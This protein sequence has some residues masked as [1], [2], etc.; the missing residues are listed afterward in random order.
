MADLRYFEVGEM[1]YAA[2]DDAGAAALWEE[3]TGEPAPEVR[4]VAGDAELG[5]VS[6]RR[7][8]EGDGPVTWSAVA[9]LL[10]AEGER[11]PF[12]IGSTYD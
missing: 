4:E 11:A 6:V 12:P 7:M 9:G 2:G 3:E 10:L 8:P 5:A 1:F